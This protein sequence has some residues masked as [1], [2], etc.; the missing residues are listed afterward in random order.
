MYCRKCPAN[1]YLPY[2]NSTSI[3]DCISC[4]SGLVSYE[5]SQRCYDCNN[6]NKDTKYILDLC[7][8][9]SDTEYIDFNIMKC[10]PCGNEEFVGEKYSTSCMKCPEFTTYIE[11]KKCNL[12]RKNLSCLS[13]NCKIILDDK[14]LQKFS[15][16]S[17]L[18]IVFVTFMAIIICCYYICILILHADIPRKESKCLWCYGLTCIIPSAG[19]I[20]V[21]IQ[22]GILGAYKKTL[23]DFNDLTLI[24]SDSNREFKLE[25]S[26]DWKLVEGELLHHQ[27]RVVDIDSFIQNN[28]VYNFSIFPYIY[29]YIY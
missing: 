14:F 1:T 19:L 22:F 16:D 5:G 24:Y 18:A 23:I 10:I 27:D 12:D 2:T 26:Y 3:A 9:C 11:P 13:E 15:Y 4:D 25:Y 29:I 17:T 20:V 28:L 7:F 8:D 6:Y 21:L